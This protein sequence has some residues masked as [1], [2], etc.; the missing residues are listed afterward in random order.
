MCYSMLFCFYF[1]NI[2]NISLRKSIFDLKSKIKYELYYIIFFF[3]YTNGNTN[4]SGK[5]RLI[6]INNPANIPNHKAAS[7]GAV[8]R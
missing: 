7:T 2:L 8:E 1:L 6:S 4:A 5:K 3:V